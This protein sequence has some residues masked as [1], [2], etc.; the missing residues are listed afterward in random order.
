MPAAGTARRMALR[1]PRASAMTRPSC[2]HVSSP[3]SAAEPLGGWRGVDA[4]ERRSRGAAG[5]ARHEWR[6]CGGHAV[7]EQLYSQRLK[8]PGER[9]TTT[10]RQSRRT[11]MSQRRPSTVPTASQQCPY[12]VPTMSPRDPP[13]PN[14][15]T[16]SHQCVAT[17]VPPRPPASHA[18]SLQQIR[19]CPP[20]GGKTLRRFGRWKNGIRGNFQNALS[21]FAMMKMAAAVSKERTIRPSLS[22]RRSRR[23]FASSQAQPCS[24]TH[25][26]LPSPEPWGSPTLRMC[27]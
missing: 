25:R 10:T 18:M 24:T 13:R 2:V 19:L 15:P 26:T 27:G 21:R 16:A 6:G 20:S 12:N 7:V 14:V 5:A 3:G 22:C 1:Y 8:E 9:Q 11:S 23:L 4:A 17:D